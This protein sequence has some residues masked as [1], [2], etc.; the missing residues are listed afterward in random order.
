MTL[1]LQELNS[2]QR[3]WSFW[4]RLSCCAL[5]REELL[6]SAALSKLCMEDG[7]RT[8]RL[9]SDLLLGLSLNMYSCGPL[10]RLYPF[11]SQGERHLLG[12]SR[13]SSQMRGAGVGT[14]RSGLGSKPHTCLFFF[15]DCFY[16]F[17]SKNVSSFVLGLLL[18]ALNNCLSICFFPPTF[19]TSFTG[20]WQELWRM[21]VMAFQ[22][23]V[24]K[25]HIFIIIMFF[26][27]FLCFMFKTLKGKENTTIRMP[28]KI[29]PWVWRDDLVN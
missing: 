23:S 10:R 21:T 18:E 3:R 20:T 16:R 29:S 8:E 2:R 12:G 1:P 25:Q 7:R 22:Q 15:F 17:F 11:C 5:F 26:K 27:I 14:S 13:E 9:L 19:L 4:F 24:S 28:L 6:V